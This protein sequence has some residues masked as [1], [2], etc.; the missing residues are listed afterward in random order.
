MVL[1]SLSPSILII[2]AS[3]SATSI[4]AASIASPPPSPHPPHSPSRPPHPPPPQGPHPCVVLLRYRASIPAFSS[5]SLPPLPPQSS[6]PPSLLL[7][8][9]RALCIRLRHADILLQPPHLIGDCA[10]LFHHR[11]HCLSHRHPAAIHVLLCHALLFLRCRRLRDMPLLP[12]HRV[13]FME[14]VADLGLVVVW[15]SCGRNLGDIRGVRKKQQ[16]NGGRE[17]ISYGI[18]RERR[19]E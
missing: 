18:R 5:S 19:N 15:F 7:L 12:L 4:A 8:L 16:W 14:T 11:R 2:A 6:L 17:E 13:L 1:N 3:A 10:L 9:R